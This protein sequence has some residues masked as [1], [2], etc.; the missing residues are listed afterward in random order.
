V[1]ALSNTDAFGT[2]PIG[3]VQLGENTPGLTYD[4]AL[5]DVTV[6]TAFIP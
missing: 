3:R 5:D 4:I 1:S 2:T 6:S